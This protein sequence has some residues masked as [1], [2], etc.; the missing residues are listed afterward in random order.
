[1]E[2]ATLSLAKNFAAR[3]MPGILDRYILSM[4]LGVLGITF[5]SLAGLF[6]LIDLTNNI[7]EFVTYGAEDGFGVLWQ[8]YGPRVLQ[9]FDRLGPVIVLLSS[10]FAITRLMKTNELVAIMA[11]G[12]SKGRVI[13]PLLW[14]A[15][16]VS[17]ISVVNRECWIPAVRE[18]LTRNAQDWRGNRPNPLRPT[19]D[20][21]TDIFLGGKQSVAAERKILQAQFRLPPALT[22]G[23]GQQLLAESAKYDQASAEHPAGYLLD[24][25]SSPADLSGIAS[26]AQNNQPLILSPKDH[27][28]LGPKQC[29]VVSDVTFEQLSG[30]SLW[31]SLSSS[32]ELIAALR[33]PSL[34]LG[35]ETRVMVHARIV[36]PFLDLTL[37]VLGLPLVIK[38]DNRNIFVASGMCLGLVAVF[39][40]TVMACHALGSSYLLSPALGAWLP[41]FI[42]TPAA[43]TAV[44]PLW[45]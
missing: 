31:R 44:V 27:A 33:N 21:K 42:F 16:V 11:A 32:R 40:V 15:L 17:V 34:D 20:Y 1:A 4:F 12:V 25:V 6:V 9:F 13:K 24:N 2:Q 37:L 8:Y 39:L 5:T 43:Y 22:S 18:Q 38:R 19:Y 30:G 36:Q 35:N 26:A 7:D 41:L 45:R 14:A 10:I 23:F 29:F 3:S 28:W